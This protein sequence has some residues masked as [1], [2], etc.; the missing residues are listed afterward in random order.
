[1]RLFTCLFLL[2][3]FASTLSMSVSA[4][5]A[6]YK[7]KIEAPINDVH[8]RVY[9]ALEK[10]RFWVVFET[11]IGDNLKRFEDKWGDEYNQNQLE[12]FQ[13]MVVCNGWYANKVSN[14]DP[15]ALALCPL[16]V[17]LIHKQGI[18]TVLFA[19]PSVFVQ[20]S[21]ALKVIDEVESLIIEAIETAA[22]QITRKR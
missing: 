4:E 14:A 16:K 19:R 7:N 3:I 18:T 1:M 20:N 15:T 17:N 11:N 12:G 21:P 10:Q 9:E 8:D 13:S 6:I 5:E 22:K 2:F